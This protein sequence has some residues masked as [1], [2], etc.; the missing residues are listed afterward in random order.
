MSIDMSYNFFLR[1]NKNKE[2]LMNYLIAFNYVEAS[3]KI[4]LLD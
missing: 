1:L 4:F 2:T 3:Y